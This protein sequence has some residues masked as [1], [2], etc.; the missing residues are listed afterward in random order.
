V[1]PELQQMLARPEFVALVALGVTIV[2]CIGLALIVLATIG[3]AGLIGGLQRADE[4]GSVTFGEAWRIGTRYFWRMI[5][6]ALVL[7]VPLLVFAVLAVIT[8]VQTFG[9]ALLLII[10]LACVFALAYIPFAIVAHFAQYA[11]VLNDMHVGDAF[12]KGWAVLQANLGPIVILGVLLIVIGFAAGI[13][14]MAPFLAFI[15]PVAVMSGIGGPR[16]D[17]SVIVLAA[18]GF[19]LYLAVALLLSGVLE[20][21]STAVWTLAW[22]QFTG[23][24]R[25]TVATVPPAAP[26]TA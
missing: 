14:A 17:M 18:I 9:L 7:I 23:T 1:P 19:L 8:A 10:P 15:V 6:I 5:G 11:V 24:A 22:K 21:W 4:Q 2:L 26:V 20:T 3:R 25:I 13:L 16:M 12:R